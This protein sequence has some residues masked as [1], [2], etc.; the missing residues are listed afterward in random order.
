MAAV[1]GTGVGLLAMAAPRQLVRL[2]GGD[3]DEV[4]GFASLGWRLFAARNLVIA[5]AAFLGSTA[6]RDAV[7]AIQAPDQLVFAHGL[8][9]GSIPRRSSL[10]AMAAS[11]AVVAL[12]LAARRAD[13]QR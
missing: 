4:G 11:G 5:P 2:F 3:P 6:A 8:L 7:L 12:C 10:L 1:V 9:S 13:P